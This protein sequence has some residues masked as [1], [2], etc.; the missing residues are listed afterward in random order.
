MLTTHLISYVS[1]LAFIRAAYTQN[2]V[3]SDHRN[4]TE[5][6]LSDFVD[7]N[8]SST[9]VFQRSSSNEFSNLPQLRDALNIFDISYLAKQ[10]FNIQKDVSL[11]CSKDIYKYLNALNN[12]SMWALKTLQNQQ[13]TLPIECFEIC[14]I[15]NI[16]ENVFF[17]KK[18]N[19]IAN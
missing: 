19:S 5:A 6:T 1:L 8:R 2:L 9:V 14:L 16:K 15:E 11:N 4:D 17:V 10:W 3:N 18:S 13:P 7:L 12:S